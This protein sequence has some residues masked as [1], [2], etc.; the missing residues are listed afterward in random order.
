MTKTEQLIKMCK[1]NKGYLFTSEVM[2]AGISRTYL[3]KF[4]KENNMERVAQG[5][6]IC[7]DTWLDELYILQ[8]RYEA[9]VYTGMTALY[10]HGLIDREYS[11][12]E[13]V[14]PAPFNGGR[15]REEGVVVHQIKPEIFE[16]G[17]TTVDTN[18]GNTVRVHDKE[19]CICDT[20]LH[21]GQIE[22]QYFQTALKEYMSETDKRLS[23]LMKY[24]EK[25]NMRDEVMKYVEVMT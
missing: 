13:V 7:E 6:Y 2:K 4:V 20:I 3:A 24:A 17:I 18:F 12:I 10:L 15:L 14:V 25:M 16:L 1:K 23:V 22:V 5:I 19:K 8:K 21:R 9:I 11:Q